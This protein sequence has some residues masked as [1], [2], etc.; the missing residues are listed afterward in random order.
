VTDDR[1]RDWEEL[2]RAAEPM[3]LLPA[4]V[5]ETVVVA[6][7]AGHP[8]A[9][10]IAERV[11]EVRVRLMRPA[12]NQADDVVQIYLEDPFVSIATTPLWALAI[13]E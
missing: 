4:K 5:G 7:L 12:E 10:E 1:E 6:L 9:A 8:Q 11:G 3:R 2:E 13:D